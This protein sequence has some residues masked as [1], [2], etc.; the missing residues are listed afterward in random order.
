MYTRAWKSQGYRS[1]TYNSVSGQTACQ[2]LKAQRSIFFLSICKLLNKNKAE[3]FFK[4]YLPRLIT[5]FFTFK[6]M[7]K[8]NCASRRDTQKHVRE[9]QMTAF[10]DRIL[11]A[12]LAI[13]REQ[14]EESLTTSCKYCIY[15]LRYTRKT[16]FYILLMHLKLFFSVTE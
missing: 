10:T 6:T 1:L 8:C 15:T 11:E 9:S 5:L 4:S 7:A 14:R 12:S 3:R 13:K 2:Q 16:S